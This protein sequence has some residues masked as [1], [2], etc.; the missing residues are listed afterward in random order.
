MNSFLT[1]VLIGFA[2]C[3]ICAAAPAISDARGV[4]PDPSFGG[5]KGW[6]TTRVA[7]N[8][9]SAGAVT[10]LRDGAIVIAGGA[11]TPSGNGQILV[12]RYRPN[13]QLDRSFASGG[14]FKSTLPVANGPFLATSVAQDGSTGKLL[15]AGGYGLDSM[16]VMRL[17]S[18]GR[19]DR[20]FGRNRTGYATVAAG[21]I[22]GSIAL[23][24]DG[25][26]LVGGSNQNSN[27]RPMVVARFTRSGVL[28][29]RFGRGGL[30]QILFW[31]PILAA[32]STISG[33]QSVR[34][35]GVIGFGHIDYIGGDGHGSVGVFQLAASGRLVRSFGTAG[36]AEVAFP[37]GGGTRKFAQWFP[38]AMAVDSRG[39]ATITGDGSTAAGD[40]LLSVRLTQR[41]VPDRSYGQTRNG[42]SV[43]Q[44]LK[45]GDET[46]CGA[47][48]TAG[49][50]L[51]VGV[52]RVLAQLQPD[53]SANSRFGRNGFFTVTA[54]RGVNINGVAPW[55][56]SRIVIA[57]SAGVNSAYV[58]RYQLPTG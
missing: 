56:S 27:G 6:V 20:T 45:A 16:L 37:N 50:R 12:A 43:I 58:A 32:G 4:G 30:V 14:I 51:T 49:G 25:G 46:T 26:I 18:A 8:S 54:P 10:V 22:A 19:L 31:N 41:G 15:I 34:G 40:A 21:G 5:G 7:G 36:H 3:L 24:P 33:L 55:G 53:G 9:A 28:D 52:G 29:R 57:G 1:K 47:T 42:R 48:P 44:G 11:V 38:C 2:I 35:G 17:T 23:Q 13:G 39:R